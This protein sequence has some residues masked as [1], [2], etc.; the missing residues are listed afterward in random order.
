MSAYAARVCGSTSTPST[1]AWR[2]ND[3]RYDGDD[4]SA[5][6]ASATVAIGMAPT[7]GA[8]CEC[9]AEWPV[10]WDGSLDSNIVWSDCIFTGAGLSLDTSVAFG[11]DWK[12]STMYFSHTYACS[13]TQGSNGMARGSVH[14]DLDCTTDTDNTTHCELRGNS[15]TA[16]LSVSTKS[17]SSIGS[18]ATCEDN[19]KAYQSWQLED[20]HRQY[21]LAP[22]STTSSPSSDTGPSFTLRNLANNGVFNCTP[23][24]EAAE[25]VFQGNCTAAGASSPYVTSASFQFDPE[26]DILSI[27][28][29]YTC[30]GSTVDATGVA[31]IQ[32]TCDRQGNT[33][34]CTS[35]PLWVGTKA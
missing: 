15:T 12:N 3:A 20:W 24:P 2:I 35:L 22:G 7:G 31:Y 13:D 34:S 32:A 5:Q 26:L 17:V 33:L 8:L 14:L 18:N 25:N 23:S 19:S 11:L 10:S 21:E 9:V 28:E 30:G 27:T 4:P 16:S 1:Y 6:N 29:R